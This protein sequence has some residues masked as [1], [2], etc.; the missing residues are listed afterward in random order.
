[1]GSEDF[2]REKEGASRWQSG[3]ATAESVIGRTRHSGASIGGHKM[4]TRNI[5]QTINLGIRQNVWNCGSV[6]V[7]LAKTEIHHGLGNQDSIP[8]QQFRDNSN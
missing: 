7:R 3:R 8:V 2:D 1:M 5:L 6:T 4:K